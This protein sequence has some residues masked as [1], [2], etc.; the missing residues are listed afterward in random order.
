MHHTQRIRLGLDGGNLRFTIPSR[1]VQRFGLKRGDKLDMVCEDKKLIVD[2][3]TVQCTKL[4]DPPAE[5]P[6]SVEAAWK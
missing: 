3:S 1:V 6:E 5:V 2:L 4:F